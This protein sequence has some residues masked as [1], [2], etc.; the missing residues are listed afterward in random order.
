MFLL[1]VDSTTLMFKRD[2]RQQAREVTERD[3]RD[4]KEWYIGYSKQPP[5]KKPKHGI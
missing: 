2:P 5:V 4:A 1:F 3:F